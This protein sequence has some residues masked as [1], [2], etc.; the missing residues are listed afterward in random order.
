MWIGTQKKGI[1]IYNESGFKFG[2]VPLEDV[3]CA[4]PGAGNTCWIGTDSEGLKLL[5]RTS[6]KITS[7]PTQPMA[8]AKR[9][10]GHNYSS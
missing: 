4:A 8:R 10:N 1:S 5:D 9:G 2:L 3:N 6:G 7:Y